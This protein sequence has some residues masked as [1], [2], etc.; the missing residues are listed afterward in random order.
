[1][2]PQ[3]S[4]TVKYAGWSIEQKIKSGASVGYNEITLPAY[5]KVKQIVA[6]T[7][8]NKYNDL[9]IQSKSL[10]GLSYDGHINWTE[11]A[12]IDILEAETCN[13]IIT[14]PN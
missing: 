8:T 1:M 6:H 10:G 2:T 5:S 4:L 3:N 13:S 7:N 9:S 11:A 12:I 14:T